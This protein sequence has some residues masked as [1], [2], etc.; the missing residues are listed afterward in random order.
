MNEAV[1]V[2]DDDELVRSG[3]AMN[4]ERAG[5]EVLT[6]CDSAGVRESMM[7]QP[8]ALVLCDLV[9]GDENGMDILRFLQADYPETAV[10]IIT[11][12]GSIRNALEALKGGASD[13]IQKPADPEEVIHRV[14]MVL[15]SINLRRSLSEE[16]HRAEDRKKL[17]HEQLSRAERMSSLGTLAEGA[18]NDLK[19]ILSPVQSF[20]ADISKQIDASMEIQV[21]LMELH[22]ALRKASAVICDL[23]AIGKSNTLKKS[24]LQLNGLITEYLKSQEF[25]LATSVNSKVKVE[26]ILDESLPAVI[27]SPDHLRQMI[28]NLTINAL[29]SM[30]SGGL[31]RIH[32]TCEKLEN[33]SGRY[34]SHKPGEYVL[35]RFE[36]SAARM[37][38]EDLDRIF[39]PFYVRS[40]MGRRLLSGLGLTMV[41]RV[42]EDHG[43]FV[44]I[45]TEGGIGNVLTVCLPV[46]DENDVAILELRADYT[47]RE[48]I[49]LVDEAVEEVKARL[50]AAPGKMPFDL[51]VI[52]L[53]LGDAFDGVETFKAVLE[54]VP[55]QKAVLASGFADITR[56]VEARKLGISRSFQKPYNLEVLGKNIRMALDE[57]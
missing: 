23:E 35:L 13:Y 40:K 48:S 47:G 25:R 4:L 5:F 2:V 26:T 20:P 21:R 49:L 45:S 12:H 19:D 32:T 53:V 8:V 28:A 16:R 41:F 44:D 43:G 22:E 30:T 46:S 36:D 6:A 31:L 37:S 55:D 17:I 42:V 27:G 56:I 39:E 9:L 24:N 38:D 29:E 54:L 15:N 51:M 14:Q 3:L 11:G 7:R 52:D 57:G 33:P 10:M 18:A 34:G 1:M 50:A